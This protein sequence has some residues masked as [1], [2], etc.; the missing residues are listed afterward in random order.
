MFIFEFNITVKKEI[1]KSYHDWLLT[2]IKE[3][4]LKQ[5]GFEQA[6]LS[7]EL[8][9]PDE[10]SRK[11]SVRYTVDTKESYEKYAKGI[12]VQLRAEAVKLFQDKFSGSMRFIDTQLVMHREN[13]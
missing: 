4:M 3:K 13:F 12:G 6:T 2:N 5:D 1:Y 9:N 11:I 8:D 7:E 10:D